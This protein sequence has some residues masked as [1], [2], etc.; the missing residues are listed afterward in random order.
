MKINLPLHSFHIPV[1]GLAFTIDSPVKVARFGISSVVSIIEDR[2]I[3]TMRKYYYENLQLAYHP[4]TTKDPDYRA[5]RIT[6]YLN[7]LNKIVQDQM[8]KLKS[9]AFTKGS[10]LVKYFEML[11]CES[12]LRQLYARM[13]QTDN[14]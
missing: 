7:L 5:K 9:S 14:E 4:I 6:D 3:E 13:T 8:E 10:E 11:P 2:L 12:K 1:M